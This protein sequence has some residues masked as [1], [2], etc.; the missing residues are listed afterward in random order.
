L[1]SFCVHLIGHSGDQT[2]NFY[3]R[4]LIIKADGSVIFSPAKERLAR[5]KYNRFMDTRLALFED[6]SIYFD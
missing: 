4:R 6:K 1:G 3:Q 2:K 5:V